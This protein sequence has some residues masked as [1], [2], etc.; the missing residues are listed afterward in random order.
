MSDPATTSSARLRA[1]ERRA[2]V[3]TAA[4]DLFAQRGYAG[5]T[6]ADIAHAAGVT[7]PIVY[8]HFESKQHLVLVL[9]ER[10]RD[11]LAA[12][13]LDRLLAT[14][15]RPIAERIDAML[16]AW[17]EYVEANPFV[18]LLLHDTSG[19][20]EVAALVEELH[21]RQR[22]ADVALL[23]E[24]APHLPERELPLLGETIRASLSGLGV[25]RLD[26]PETPLDD[27]VAALRRVVLGL[28]G[29]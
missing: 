24:F 5:T 25:Y 28:L 7:K 10:Y 16:T 11:E 2:V 22:A 6:I 4:A 20:P 13:P 23:R 12:A 26:H 8:R 29:P 14:A 9:L 19:D 21:G 17:F 1:R 15:E 3:E 18:R 27:A